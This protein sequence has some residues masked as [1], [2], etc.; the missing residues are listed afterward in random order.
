[1]AGMHAHVIP[2]TFIIKLK[3][4]T[5]TLLA[6]PCCLAQYNGL[7][8]V[9][10]LMQCSCYISPTWKQASGRE[11]LFINDFS[12][13]WILPI[14]NRRDQSMQSLQTRRGPFRLQCVVC[15]NLILNIAFSS[16]LLAADAT[17]KSGTVFNTVHRKHALSSPSALQL[18]S[19]QFKSAAQLRNSL[20]IYHTEAFK[21][22]PLSP[23][24]LSGAAQVAGSRR[25]WSYWA[26]P[27]CE[28]VWLYE[29]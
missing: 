7:V 14:C 19:C 17:V 24:C 4:A 12:Q 11:R 9:H 2:A 1:M 26:A 15:Y 27:S 29:C 5:N 20:S 22:R 16:S 13:V 6:R 10:G 18:E 25:M 28:H 8:I 23:R 3:V 21:A